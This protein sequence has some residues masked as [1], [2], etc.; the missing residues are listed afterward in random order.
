MVK[1]THN[2]LSG[3][4]YNK[5]SQ[6]YADINAVENLRISTAS[7]TAKTWVRNLRQSHSL[8]RDTTKANIIN[9]F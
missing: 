1:G 2:Q 4:E 7:D 6:R 3:S 8:T 5:L 9:S